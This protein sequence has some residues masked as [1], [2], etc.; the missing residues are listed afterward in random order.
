MLCH[1]VLVL[2]YDRDRYE[3][4]AQAVANLNILN[5]LAG[6]KLPVYTFSGSKTKGQCHDMLE[7]SD[8]D[9][10]NCDAQFLDSLILG[11]VLNIKIMYSGQNISLH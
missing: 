5:N 11:Q 6:A 10:E 7:S 3:G 4:E 9:S 8:S 1:A 2:L